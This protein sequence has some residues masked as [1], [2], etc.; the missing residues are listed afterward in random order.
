MNRNNLNRR[1]GTA[2]ALQVLLLVAIVQGVIATSPSVPAGFTEVAAEKFPVT[3][4]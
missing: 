4:S 2:I 1:P 3:L